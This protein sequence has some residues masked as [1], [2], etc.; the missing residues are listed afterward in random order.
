MIKCQTQ[1]KVVRFT[2]CHIIQLSRLV[3]SFLTK[4]YHRR[5]LSHF[6][7]PFVSVTLVS[8][9]SPVNHCTCHSV[10]CNLHE[11]GLKRTGSRSAEGCGP[12]LPHTAE[13]Q[14]TLTHSITE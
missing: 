2:A 6:V 12:E 1:L 8:S 11:M 5:R 3:E 9:L 13:A 10:A 14:F 7:S 4:S